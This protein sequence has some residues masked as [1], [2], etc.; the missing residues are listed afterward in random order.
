MPL[1]GGFMSLALPSKER[2]EDNFGR[3][4]AF[5]WGVF[6][7]LLLILAMAAVVVVALKHFL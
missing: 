3:V 2:I 6:E 4:R 1:F 5:L 7:V